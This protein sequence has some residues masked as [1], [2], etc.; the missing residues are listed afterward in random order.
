[1]KSLSPAKPEELPNGGRDGVDAFI[2]QG[3]D[4]LVAP[5]SQ[6]LY[7]D[8]MNGFSMASSAALAEVDAGGSL[9]QGGLI[10]T[11]ERGGFE[12]S[13]L[14]RPEFVN[15][16]QIAELPLQKAV[17]PRTVKDRVEGVQ[18]IRLVCNVSFLLRFF[19]NENVRFRHPIRSIPVLLC[20][21]RL[22]RTGVGSKAQPT[23]LL[24]LI[25]G[26]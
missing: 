9:S 24:Q 7:P 25:D 2:G 21:T 10:G 13:E 19:V 4:L 23:L 16:P 20:R 22:V 11:G 5:D 6:R 8:G 17:I 15:E 14:E 18:V 1:M 26:G 3:E 12:R